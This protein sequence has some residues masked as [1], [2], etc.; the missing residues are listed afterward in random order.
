MDSNTDTFQDPRTIADLG[1]FVDS[2]VGSAKAGEAHATSL[3]TQ[4]AKTRLTDPDA[5]DKLDAEAAKQFGEAKKAYAMA[6]SVL[7]VTLPSLED[8]GK[9][10]DLSALDPFKKQASGRST[11]P[12]ISAPPPIMGEPSSPTQSG[13]G[14]GLLQKWFNLP[15]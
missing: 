5:A 14:G 2:L 7:G 3:L 11:P 4:S 13:G 12:P 15:Q 9:P 6:Y 8:D 1:G 10:K